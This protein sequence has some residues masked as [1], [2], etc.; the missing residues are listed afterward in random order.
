M[1]WLDKD[2]PGRHGMSWDVAV[3]TGEAGM[4]RLGLERRGMEWQVGNGKAWLR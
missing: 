4:V 1:A 2:R 3:T